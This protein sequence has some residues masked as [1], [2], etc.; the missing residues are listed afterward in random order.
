MQII[1]T[2]NTDYRLE[3]SD[4]YIE[5][6]SNGL[7]KQYIDIEKL[8]RYLDDILQNG[9][10]LLAIDNELVIGAILCCP[11]KMDGDVPDDIS[12]NFLVEK[13]IY[14]A[15][16]MVKEQA[17]GMGIGT[18]LLNEFFHTVDTSIFTN[19]FIRV[20]DENKGAIALY[21][22]FGFEAVTIIEQTKKKAEG[23]GTFVMKKIYLHKKL[24]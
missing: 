23:D 10:A 5:A 18:K 17:R 9:Y 3:I 14:V 24:I 13:C 8:R 19:A 7:S 1:K 6:F 21:Q 20:W 2:N 11:L 15:E 4:L 12:N 22:K 16:M